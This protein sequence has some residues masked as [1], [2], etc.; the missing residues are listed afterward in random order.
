MNARTLATVA[1]VAGLSFVAAACRMAPN[2]GG[3]SP[4]TAAAPGTCCVHG[5]H[6]ATDAAGSTYGAPYGGYGAAY[7]QPAANPYAGQYAA[8]QYGG[9]YGYG[10]GYGTQTT[11]VAGGYAPMGAPATIHQAPGDNCPVCRQQA[12]Q[13]APR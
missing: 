8:P 2:M 4:A 11:P 13:Y 12:Q 5:F 1:T 6:G 10:Y 9:G 3:A 7:A